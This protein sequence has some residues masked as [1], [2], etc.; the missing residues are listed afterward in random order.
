MVPIVKLK[1]KLADFLNLDDFENVLLDPGL[2]SL[3]ICASFDVDCFSKGMVLRVFESALLRIR[4]QYQDLLP[5]YKNL[6]FDTTHV[7]VNTK[8]QRI[9]RIE[10]C[11]IRDIA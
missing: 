6:V 1:M 8:S 5:D 10:L 3:G 9:A 2:V 4:A 7:I 11:F